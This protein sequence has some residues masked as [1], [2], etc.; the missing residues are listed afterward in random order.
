MG[1]KQGRSFA[2][3]RQA[4][5]NVFDAAA[6]TPSQA[7]PVGQAGAVRQLERGRV[8]AFGSVLSEH[9]LSADRMAADWR[10]VKASAQ[11]SP[12]SVL[13]LEHGFETADVAVIAE[14]DVL[15]DRLARPRRKKKTADVISEA[16]ALTPGDLVVHADHG[17]GRYLGLKTLSVGEAPHDCL[18]LEYA[19]QSKL[20]LPVENIELLSRYGQDS[21]TAQLDKLG[22]GAWQARKAKAKKR[23][24][25]MADQLI[26]I[27]AQRNAREAEV[28]EPPSGLYDEFAARFP[29]AETDDQLNAIEDVFGDLAK[30]RRWTG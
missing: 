11:R 1:G 10:A 3:E 7:A 16:G 23:L 12:A 21:E 22:G 15:G 28:I 30:G 29:Y 13:P 5:Q 27:A 17:L 20:Y 9:G 8:R 2:A 25:D 18:E 19:G 6:S 4:D 26:K 14:Q 24:R